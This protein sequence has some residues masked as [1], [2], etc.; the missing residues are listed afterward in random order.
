MIYPLQELSAKYLWNKLVKQIAADSERRRKS[1]VVPFT[2]KMDS[3]LCQSEN[4][5]KCQKYNDFVVFTHT[6]R[7]KDTKQLD[8]FMYQW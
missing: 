2:M 3:I 6:H 8:S 1:C 4:G 7:Q 5:N